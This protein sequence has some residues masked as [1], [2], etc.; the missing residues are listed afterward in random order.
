MNTVSVPASHPYNVLIGSGLLKELGSYTKTVSNAQRICIVSDTNVWPLYGNSTS[1]SLRNAGFH[2]VHF[3][4]PAGEESKNLQ[5]FGKLLNFLTDNQITRSDLIVAL[6]GGICGDLAGFAAATYLRGI[7][8]IQ[9]PTTLLAAVDSS[10]GGKTAIDLPGGKN[11]AGA[12]HQP[13]MVLCLS[14]IHI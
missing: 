1:V 13:V 7:P 6:G 5:T 11:L 8:Y 14:L 4:F 12:F 10:V 9:I 3:I 2:V